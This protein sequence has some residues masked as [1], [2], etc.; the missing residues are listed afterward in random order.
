VY[1]GPQSVI[2]RGVTIGEHAVIGANSFVNRDVP[3]YAI[4]A[5]TP[6]RAIGRVVVEGDDVRFEYDR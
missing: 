4:A 1:V 2:A 3:P 6:A 5:G